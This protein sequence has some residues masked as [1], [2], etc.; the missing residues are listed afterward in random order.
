MPSFT[1]RGV[2]AVGIV[3]AALVLLGLHSITF[4]QTLALTG[5]VTALYFGQY[6][7]P[8]GTTAVPTDSVVVQ[9]NAN[10]GKS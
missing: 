3:A 9:P 1:V 8:P 6:V 2:L 7:Q 10:G 5:P 4:D